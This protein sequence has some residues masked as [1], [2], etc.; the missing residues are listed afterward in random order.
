MGDPVARATIIP[1]FHDRYL[2]ASDGIRLEVDDTKYDT[3]FVLEAINSPEFRKKA[4]SQSTG[5]TRQRISLSD[6]KML[7]IKAPKLH[8]QK[9]IAMISSACDEEVILLKQ[10]L[11]ALRHQKQGLMQQ[12]LTGKIRVKV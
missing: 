7:T 1:T 11:T 2:M 9:K 10:K 3:K 6:L 4:I 5:S 8:E 12:L